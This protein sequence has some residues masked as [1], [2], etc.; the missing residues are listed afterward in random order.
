MNPVTGLAL[1][2]V[3]VGAIALG[4]PELAG[5]LFQLDVANNPQL[6]YFSRLFGSR[7]IAIGALTLLARGS[8]RRNLVLAGI[9]IDAADGATGYLGMRDGYLSRSTAMALTGP[10]VGAV[11]AGLAGLRP[12]GKRT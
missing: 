6:P 8:T 2:R 1:G 5:R 7:E 11:L 3:A 9:A 4:N 10:A 12:R